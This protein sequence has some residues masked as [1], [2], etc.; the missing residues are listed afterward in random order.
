MRTTQLRLNA[1]AKVNIVIADKN[2]VA[3]SRYQRLSVTR[4][5]RGEIKS[6]NCRQMRARK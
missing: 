1:A 4:M 6:Q 2:H 5:T 3:S